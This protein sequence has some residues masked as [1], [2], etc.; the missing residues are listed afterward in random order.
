MLECII[1]AVD[2]KSLPTCECAPCTPPFF[3]V[4]RRFFSLFGIYNVFYQQ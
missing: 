2:G 1:G 4:R 3:E